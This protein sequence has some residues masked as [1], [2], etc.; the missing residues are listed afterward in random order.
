MNT[1]LSADALSPMMRALTGDARRTRISSLLR[2]RGPMT[3]AELS[4]ATGIAKSSMSLLVDQLV[5]S[6]EVSI[7]VA[8]PTN[9]SRTVRG[10][11]GELVELNA[12][13]GAAIGLEFGYGHVRGIIGDISH[14]MLAK[15]EVAIGTTLDARETFEIAQ[16]V[17]TELLHASRITP[18]RVLGIGVSVPLA[19][20]D[21]RAAA[22][23]SRAQ[24]RWK[25]IDIAAEL[26]VLT[27][28]QVLVEN[29][30]NL[31]A[32]AE[33]L[34]GAQKENFIYIRLQAGVGGAIVVN[35]RV[36]TGQ[37]GAA[38]EIGH[39]PLDPNGPVCQC[40]RRGCLDAYAGI[41]SML[42]SASA[43]F[44]YE[45][46]FQQFLALVDEGDL[47]CS[48]ILG[49]ATRHIGQA[50][51]MLCN[52]LNPGAVILGGS[53]FAA[54]QDLLSEVAEAFQS[55]AVETST[56][57]QILPGDFGHYSSA[58]GAVAL[59]LGQVRPGKETRR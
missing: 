13:S 53:L 56:D 16:R 9:R 23:P 57:L 14:D 3:R 5:A 24:L 20:E 6:G 27:G 17:V 12:S 36:I 54:R 52:V 35:H 45:I 22:F 37:H 32:Y 2:Q 29:D 44:G 59:A 41:S 26:S 18:S 55:F 1:Y 58:M 40:G 39:L 8:T 33:L 38:G 28:F 46:G 19:V 25:G 31:A 10:R 48:R 50:M 7:R 30:A 51:G 47:V 4:R 49:D 11:P 43:A 34:W 42:A 21:A 15:Q